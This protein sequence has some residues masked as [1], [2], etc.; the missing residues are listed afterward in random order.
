MRNYPQ[1]FPADT[2][3]DRLLSRLSGV[4]RVGQNAWMALCPAHND[5]HPSL[6][7]KETSDGAILIHCWSGCETRDI[8]QAVDL[9]FSDLF[10]P[11]PKRDFIYYGTRQNKDG[12]RALAPRQARFSAMDALRSLSYEALVVYVA[13]SHA[14]DG[15]L[16]DKGRR[17]LELA[18]SRIRAAVEFIGGKNA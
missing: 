9:D 12:S 11:R 4:K 18:S 2:P 10:P 3:I 8:L 6:S 7:I 5:K 1:R 16:D 15:T 17:R 13:A 14:L